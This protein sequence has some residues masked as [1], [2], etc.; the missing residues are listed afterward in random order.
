MGLKAYAVKPMMSPHSKA[1]LLVGN[2]RIEIKFTGKFNA[3]F[4]MQNA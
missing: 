2:G 3:L 4:F 1:W